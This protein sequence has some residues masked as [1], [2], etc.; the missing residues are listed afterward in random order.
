M[1]VDDDIICFPKQGRTFTVC[2]SEDDLYLMT[3]KSC[4]TC[5]GVNLH[6]LKLLW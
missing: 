2:G 6:D 5:V 1:H 4:V 3:A